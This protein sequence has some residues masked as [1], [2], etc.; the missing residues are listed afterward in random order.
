MVCNVIGQR[1]IDDSSLMMT[2]N[3]KYKQVIEQAKQK[4]IDFSKMNNKSVSWELHST[5]DNMILYKGSVQDSEWIALQCH[6][7]IDASAK[8]VVDLLSDPDRT[9]EYD[10]LFDR[11]TMIHEFNKDTKAHLKYIKMKGVFPT[12]ARD[13]VSV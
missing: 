6:A 13:F 1:F 10:D 9:G 4:I 11:Y 3:L 7:V 8:T 12:K 5:S 2:E